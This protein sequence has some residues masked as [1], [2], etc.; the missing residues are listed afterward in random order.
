LY[1]IGEWNLYRLDSKFMLVYFQRLG[2]ETTKVE[3]KVYR[4][5]QI[6]TI[7]IE[8]GL[9]WKANYHHGYKFIVYPRLFHSYPT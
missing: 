5:Q 6:I 2:L 4:L 3:I 8:F 1:A 7:F 9:F